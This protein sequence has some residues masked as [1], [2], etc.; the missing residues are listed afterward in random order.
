M[1]VILVAVS[2]PRA[3][4]LRNNAKISASLTPIL[5]QNRAIDA[6]SAGGSQV[7]QIVSGQGGLLIQVPMPTVKKEEE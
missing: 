4:G 1:K 3:R 5:I 2:H 7:P 6:W